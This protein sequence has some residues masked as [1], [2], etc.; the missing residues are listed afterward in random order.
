MLSLIP[1]ILLVNECFSAPSRRGGYVLH[2]KRAAEPVEWAKTRR[3]EPDHILPLRIGLTQSN[4]HELEM[5]LMDVSD[6]ES[7]NYGK[8]WTPQEVIEAFA[9]SNDTIVTVADWLAEAGFE[10]ERLHLS[11][12]RGWLKL[13]ATTAEV[14]EL[15]QTE[16]H[17]YTH[18]S[19]VEQIGKY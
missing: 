14:E 19:G 16:Y 6:P 8:H 2:E 4:L 5:H 18:D 11:P 1:L 12:S 15:L 9:P 7:Q 17:V 13:N 10:A 3:L